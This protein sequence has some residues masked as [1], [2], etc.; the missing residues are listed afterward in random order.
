MS[1]FS[2]RPAKVAVLRAGL[3][4]HAIA[5]AFARWAC[6]VQIFDTNATVLGQLSARLAACEQDLGPCEAPVVPVEQLEAALNG[7]DFVIEA[8]VEQLEVKQDLLARSARIAPA[9]ILATNTSVIPIHAIASAIDDSSRLIGTH[10]WNPAH[11]IDIVE[12]VA[13]PSTPSLIVQQVE[14]WLRGIGKEPVPVM[15]DVPGFIG[16]RLQFAMWRE[17][18]QM[19]EEG[20][21]DPVTL[22]K[23]VRGTF[24]R[25]LAAIG[26][27]ENADLIGLDLTHAI[28]RYILPSLSTSAL[29]AKILDRLLDKG[30]LGARS[31][32]GLIGWPAGAH[33]A[34]TERLRW[35][36]A[37]HCD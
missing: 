19:V 10:W 14:T 16:N 21:C 1:Q 9:A 22:D 37:H 28:M 27:M 3:M 23:V 17:A 33:Q 5:Y 12:I 15:R 26:P 30:H 36:L 29:P 20:I 18:L 35:H 13:G 8:V 31:G 24:G 32:E 4:G 6:P 25:R 2:E 7:V 11:L 34:V